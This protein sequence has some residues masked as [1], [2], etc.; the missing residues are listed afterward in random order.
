MAKPF[1]APPPISFLAAE[2][3]ISNSTIHHLTVISNDQSKEKMKKTGTFSLAM[4]KTQ[5]KLTIVLPTNPDP[6]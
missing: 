5:E 1:L 4:N 2:F 3:T 6:F